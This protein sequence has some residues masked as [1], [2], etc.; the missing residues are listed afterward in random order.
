MIIIDLWGGDLHTNHVGH[1]E[2]SMW[3]EACDI[4]FMATENG[5]LCNVLH[6]DFQVPEHRIQEQDDLFRKSIESRH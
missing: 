2:V 5:F 3:S 1:H 6:S 4:M